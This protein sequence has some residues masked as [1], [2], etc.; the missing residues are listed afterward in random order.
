M[1]AAAP[2]LSTELHVDLM[3]ERPGQAAAEKAA[4]GVEAAAV[5]KAVSDKA[6]EV[7]WDEAP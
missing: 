5:A 7:E 4:A 2:T 3:R 6:A 1:R